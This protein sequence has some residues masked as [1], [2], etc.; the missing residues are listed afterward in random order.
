M[1]RWLGLQSPLT[2]QKAFWMASGFFAL[3]FILKVLFLAS[4]DIAM[5]E[6]FTLWWAQRPVGDIWEMAQ[7]GNNPPLHFLIEHFWM[8]QFG[9]GWMSVRFPSLLFACLAAAIVFRAGNRHF[10]LMTGIGAALIYTMST[11]HTYYSHEARTYP[12]LCLLIALVV[13]RYLDLLKSP[14]KWAHYFWLGLWSVLLIYAHFLG[15][16]VL[17][18]MA[19]GWLLL[20]QKKVTFLRLGTMFLGIGI[21]FSPSIYTFFLRVQSV[22]DTGTWVAPPHWTQLYGHVNGF[23]NGRIATAAV[24]LMLVV[25]FGS[26]LVQGK[27]RGTLQKIWKDRA[28]WLALAMFLVMYIGVYVQSLLLSPAFIPRYLIFTSIPL[29]VVLARLLDLAFEDGRW[30]VLALGIVLL[31]MGKGF[32]LDPSNHRQVWK[33]VTHVLLNRK[34]APILISPPYFDLTFLYHYNRYAFQDYNHESPDWKYM[35]IYPVE[36]WASVPNGALDAAER[37]IYVDADAQFSGHG[38][39]ILSNLEGLYPKVR[40]ETFEERMDVYVFEK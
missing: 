36:N 30:K 28:L 21:A 40:K 3:N 2:A 23:L 34:D 17:M 15:F 5:D 10:S 33:M 32:E 38:G 9:M 39:G 25:G 4:Q 19:C 6:P 31:G 26:V 29:F 8:G 1:N 35:K 7:N 12:L 20:P 37:V 16:W 18:A 14:G 13:D 11:E 24:V 27:G 22:A